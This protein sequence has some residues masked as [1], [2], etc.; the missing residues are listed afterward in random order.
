VITRRRSAN[1]RPLARLLAASALAAGA[2]SA[3]EAQVRPGRPAAPAITGDWLVPPGT[4]VV[5][6]GPCA[7]RADLLCGTITWLKRPNT[8]QGLPKTDVSNPDPALRAR[9]LVGLTV[10]QDFRPQPGGR[11]RGVFSLSG[12]SV[13]AWINLRDD[14][15]LNFKG[16]VLMVCGEQIWTRSAGSP[17]AGS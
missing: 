1:R 13:D 3:A 17:A 16:C 2:A 12:K 5:R 4:E 15:D 10:L 9:P 14:G 7:G 8:Q 11:F 6:I